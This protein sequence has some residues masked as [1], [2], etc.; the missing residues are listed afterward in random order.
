[1]AKRLVSRSDV[2]I[3]PFR[4]GIMEKMG[5]GPEVFHENEGRRGLNDRLIYARVAG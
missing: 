3:D 4:P 5:L 1:V 2:L